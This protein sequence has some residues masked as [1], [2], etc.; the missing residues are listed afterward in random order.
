MWLLCVKY[1]LVHPG[2]LGILDLSLV[3]SGATSDGIRVSCPRPVLCSF[4][5]LLL[6]SLAR[7]DPT[8]RMTA[9]GMCIFQIMATLYILFTE[10]RRWE[11]SI[12]ILLVKE[13]WPKK[14]LSQDTARMKSWRGVL[15]I[16]NN[17]NQI[18]CMTL[19]RDPPVSLWLECFC[20]VEEVGQLWHSAEGF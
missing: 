15:E 18:Q 11:T 12:S 2:V 6:K 4:C 9:F 5:C 8:L 7:L 14:L 3:F 1:I 20:V 10:H 19:C 17:N 13:Y 16:L